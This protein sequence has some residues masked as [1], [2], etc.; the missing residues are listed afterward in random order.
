MILEEVIENVRP[1]PA[2]EAVQL[3]SFRLLKIRAVG[4]HQ[5]DRLVGLFV[6]LA[7]HVETEPVARFYDERPDLEAAALREYPLLWQ[8]LLLASNAVECAG[9]AIE[10]RDRGDVGKHYRT[11]FIETLS[12]MVDA[13]SALSGWVKQQTLL[14][15]VVRRH[16]ADELR[17]NASFPGDAEDEGAGR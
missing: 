15:S 7:A 12:A 17:A 5:G 3:Q 4:S 16:V 1:V 11:A 10:L 9:L 8:V 13:L 6:A 2:V 14:P